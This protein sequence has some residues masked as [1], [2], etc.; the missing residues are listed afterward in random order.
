M[1]R[2]QGYAITTEPGKPDVE[3]DTITCGHCNGISFVPAGC[4]PAD[5]CRMC[6]RY[7][8]EACVKLARCDPFEKKL[9]RIE[10][11]DRLLRAATS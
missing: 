3:E 10:A 6:M 2:P 8:C 5:T 1:L 7:I 11:R 9:E 4:Q